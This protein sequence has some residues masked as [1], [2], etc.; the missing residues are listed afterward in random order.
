MSDVRDAGDVFSELRGRVKAVITSPPYL[1]VT[2]YEEDQWL[3]LWFLGHQPRPTYSVVSSDDRYV[4]AENY[5][6][7]LSEAW[8]GIAPL[9]CRN[10]V[11]VCRLAAK[12][13]PRRELTDNLYETLLLSF[14]RAYLI[15]APSISKIRNR[16][17]NN[18]RPNARGCFFE[19][20]YAFKLN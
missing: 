7:F 4:G 3:R 20:D 8:E 19:I 2:R 12:G 11:L 5:W 10:A 18:F 14:P 15:C 9:V 6:D 16:Q 17:T 13:I 1:N